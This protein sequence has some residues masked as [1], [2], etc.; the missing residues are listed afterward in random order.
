MSKILVFGIGLL[1]GAGLATYY[2][3]ATPRAALTAGT[4]VAPPAVELPPPPAASPPLPAAL[5]PPVAALAP[6][7]TA[8]LPPALEPPPPPAPFAADLA[9][10]APAPAAVTQPS[11]A[12]PAPRAAVPAVAQLQVPVAPAAE[13]PAPM[14]LPPRLLIPVAG[15]RASQLSDTYGDRRGAARPHE[16]LDIMAPRGTPVLAAADGKI[17]KLF[18][19]KP[20]GLTIYQFDPGE[21]VAYY[22]AHLDRYAPGIAAG[23]QVKQGELI[24]YVGSTGNASPEGPHL[25]FAI[26]RLGPEKNWW[27]GTPINP[28]PLLASP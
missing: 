27:Q 26:F 23:V 22:Y 6:L 20:G 10:R 9:A 13:P 19:S 12:A 7:A 21:T 24:G 25:H 18:D 17:V 28:Y 4:P 8:V 1:A 14:L 15:V 2:F 5:P 11:A 16:A 3:V